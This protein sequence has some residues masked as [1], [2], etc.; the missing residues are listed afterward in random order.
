MCASAS[1]SPVGTAGCFGWRRARRGSHGDLGGGRHGLA[2]RALAWSE[3]RSGRSRSGRARS[4]A[5]WTP[6]IFVIGDAASRRARTASRCREWLRSQK[7]QGAYVARLIKARAEG[8]N[9]PGPLSLSRR[10]VDGNDRAPAR[11]CANRALQVE[12][13]CRM[14]ALV[15]RTHL[16]SD[17]IPQ[18]GHCCDE[19][20]LELHYV[21]TWNTPDYRHDRRTHG[22]DADADL[23]RTENSGD[24]RHA[25]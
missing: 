9:R 25:A 10:R 12:R 1:A 7:Q 13:L 3:D 19:L 4:V 21:P 6:D 18:S 11:R 2:G 16:L 5:S 14:G 17:R 15:R 24:V 8:R 20:G 22:S 23:Q